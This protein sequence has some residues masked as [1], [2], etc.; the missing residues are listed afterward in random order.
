MIVPVAL[1]LGC[2]G[3]EKALSL[4]PHGLGTRP[5]HQLHYQERG[6]HVK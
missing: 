6:C 5:L 1:F 2:T 3:G 4:F